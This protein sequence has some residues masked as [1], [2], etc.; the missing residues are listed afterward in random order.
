MAKPDKIVILGG[1]GYL[2][3]AFLKE[4]DRRGW[5]YTNLS[6]KFCD[7]GDFDL[8][9][10]YLNAARPQFVINTAGY[11]GRPNV[12]V[13]EFLKA[14]T[15]EGNLMLPMVVAHACSALK[16]PFGHVSSGCIYN[17]S[18]VSKLEC[19][20]S[21]TP[22]FSFRNP[23]CSFY[24]GTKAMAEEAIEHVGQNYIWRVRLPFDEF[25]NERN[26]L[27]K[28]QRYEK[29]YNNTNSLS[30]RGDFVK[31]CLDLV[32]IGAPYGTYNMTNPGAVTSK[33]VV[34]MIQDTLK[35]NREFK[36]WENDE[37]F[38]KV[39]I[40][41]RSNCVLDTTKLKQAGVVMRP[42]EEALEDSLRKWVPEKC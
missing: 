21:H 42:V 20:E 24:S 8:L 23:P 41:P 5:A 36:Y 32:E 25:D 15:L 7:Y 30:H 17:V 33:Q 13:C 16:I 11:A 19:S 28:L 12:D 39:A 10:N 6:R 18:E 35:I 31:A 27:S 38:Y 9:S 3:Q 4:L 1:T 26:Y 29:V 37:E 40:A 2:G 22:N 14:S 34:G